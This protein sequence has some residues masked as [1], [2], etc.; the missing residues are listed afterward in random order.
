MFQIDSLRELFINNNNLKEITENI[1]NLSNLKVLYL[2]E[3][4]IHELPK[5]IKRFAESLDEFALKNL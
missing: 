1:L 3:N 4:Q 5:S 2:Y